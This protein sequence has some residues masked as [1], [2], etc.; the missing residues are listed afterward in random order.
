MSVAN[1]S[2]GLVCHDSHPALPDG[3][4]KIVIRC[5][6]QPLVLHRSAIYSCHLITP[7]ANSS[8]RSSKVSLPLVAIRRDSGSV[9]ASPS[10][11]MARQSP[12][13]LRHE[14]P[15][16]RAG[17]LAAIDGVEREQLHTIRV[18]LAGSGRL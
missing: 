4:K 6:A 14:Q 7:V 12:S 3:L 13:G 2:L 1:K 11:R 18:A 17:G 10:A 8:G 15:H 9:G 5:K 16:R